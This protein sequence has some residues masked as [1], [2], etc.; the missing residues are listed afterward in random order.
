MSKYHR[1]V[2]QRLQAIGQIEY[3]FPNLMERYSQLQSSIEQRL[4]WAAGANP[5]LNT[6]QQNF[7][8]A[9]EKRKQILA[10]SILVVFL[11]ILVV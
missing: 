11:F 2:L 6:V 10:V 1:F 8:K 3:S 5:A 9:T 4:K 7:E